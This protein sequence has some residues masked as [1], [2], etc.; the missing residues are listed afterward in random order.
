MDPE[1]SALAGVLVTTLIATLTQ[2]SV[3]WAKTKVATL[4]RRGTSTQD[5]DTEPELEQTRRRVREAQ[6]AG[7][8]ETLAEMREEL[9][10]QAEL[11]LTDQHS[12]VRA[13]REA[14]GEAL[15]NENPVWASTALLSYVNNSALLREMDEHWRMC[16]E[17]G[18]GTAFFL[19]GIPG[20][21]KRSTALQWVHL[22]RDVFVGE[23]LRAD[24]G[25]RQGRIP[26]ASAVLERWLQQLGAATEGRSSDVSD[27]A[28]LVRRRL[29]DRP[30]VFVLENVTTARQVRDLLT[31]QPYGVVLM[32]GQQEPH[33]LHT[34]VRNVRPLRVSPLPD[35]HALDL[36]VKLTRTSE[37][38][39]RFKPIVQY[40]GALPLA[41]RLVAEQL[42][43]PI[44]GVL[45]DVTAQLADRTTRQELLHMGDMNP[46]PEAL[47]LSYQRMALQT[48][49][50]Y[51]RLGL[52]VNEEFQLDIVYALTS[53][54]PAPEVRA[55]MN[56]LVSAGLVEV[57]GIDAYRLP[58]L[59]HD[60]ALMAAERD[61]DAR[62]R[63]A[64][65]RRIV[66]HVLHIAEKGEATLSSRWRH[67]PMN[68]FTVEE[69]KER[70]EA[71][72]LSDLGRRQ[73]II[74]ATVDL[75]AEAGLHT[76]AWR[77]AQATWTYCLKT[78]SHSRWIESRITGLAAAEESGDMMAAARMS[79]ELAFAHLDRWAIEES[80]PRLAR[81]FFERALSLVRPGTPG[82]SEGERRTESSVLEGLGLLERKLKRPNQALDLFHDARAALE[83][84]DHPRGQALLA[85]HIGGT[86]TRLERHND[87]DRELRGA[88]NQF[89]SLPAGPDRF[90]IAKAQL[91]RGEDRHACGQPHEALAVLDSAVDGMEGAG[92]EYWTATALLL[93]GRI[94]RELGE[95]GR[96]VADWT[97]ARELYK[98][99]GS[100]REDE[101]QQLLDEEGQGGEQ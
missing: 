16:Q 58:A 72:V 41:L 26:E 67:D 97:S 101:A 15:M 44:P 94:H 83:G 36:L 38:P 78:G 64:V 33:G 1:L 24:L 28:W 47:D 56:S 35:E 5:G 34:V 86:Y 8:E 63:A 66:H 80:D 20:V 59:V 12:A 50:L 70:E 37:D 6:A 21:G 11:L 46:L 2:D 84:I 32:T 98:K 62:E 7:D 71:D 14:I 29:G 88:E 99:A 10:G 96:A 76:E 100:R 92:S 54:W 81:E 3:G 4:F 51:R 82:R 89:T 87:A 13:G 19:S 79:F 49:Q 39:T 18:V 52:L 73:A 45:E 74:F 77:L 43:S 61:E 91:L 69:T 95:N 53:D 31:D 68:V 40:V 17:A 9:T 85:M 42:R 48:A 25:L 22:H 90:N 75:A 30:V 55:A 57:R 23:V 27:L 93:R 65:R 60:H